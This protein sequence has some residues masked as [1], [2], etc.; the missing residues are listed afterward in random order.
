MPLSPRLKMKMVCNCFRSFIVVVFNMSLLWWRC[1]AEA[2]AAR[3]KTKGQPNYCQGRWYLSL[4]LS[5]AFFLISVFQ[6]MTKRGIAKRKANTQTS[7][8]GR[9]TSLLDWLLSE[10]E[11]WILST[12]RGI[13][14]IPLSFLFVAFDQCAS[15]CQISLP[16]VH[17]HKITQEH[18]ACAT[19]FPNSQDDYL[20]KVC[21]VSSRVPWL[22]FLSVSNSNKSSFLNS[23]FLLPVRSHN[24]G[25]GKTF[26]GGLTPWR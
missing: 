18:Y 23:K 25:G 6:A 19:N 26:T 14:R 5:F 12:L 3:V 9:K 4:P 8:R 22:A 2:E 10:N 24:N 11:S 7:K 13:Y 16:H 20:K 17:S 1:R 15:C 21:P